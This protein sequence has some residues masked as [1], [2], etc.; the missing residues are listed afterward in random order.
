M[1]AVDRVI[2]VIFMGM[3][4]TF[5]MVVGELGFLVDVGQLMEQNTQQSGASY[6]VFI[7]AAL[8]YFLTSFGFYTIVP[9]LV[10][11]YEGNANTVRKAMLYGSLLSFCFYLVWI[12]IAMGS[13]DRVGFLPVIQEG[14]NV[15]VLVNHILNTANSDT[16]IFSI[17]I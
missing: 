5:F 10:K 3:I 11:Y 8:P 9:S 14:G 15:G 13:L 2:T 7:F 1:R 12:L 6:W 17:N 16:L 4:I